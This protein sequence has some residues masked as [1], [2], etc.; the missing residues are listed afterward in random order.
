MNEVK[1]YKGSDNLPLLKEPRVIRPSKIFFW[2]KCSKQFLNFTIFMILSSL[3]IFYFSSSTATEI[4]RIELLKEY[5]KILIFLFWIPWFIFLIVYII[6]FYY[7]GKSMVF[8]VFENGIKVKKGL[9]YISE[10]YIPF[11]T[12]TYVE[13]QAGP[14]DTFFD[15][16]TVEI[17]TT[18]V[19]YTPGERVVEKLEGIKNYCEVRDSLL[20][21]LP[22][23]QATDWT[24]VSV[25]TPT[26]INR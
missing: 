18:G 8:S 26:D 4:Q 9:F 19:Q 14:L 22:H 23:S 17:W 2:K 7:Y 10:R 24:S 1:K 13:I 25:A 6:G 20:V 16:G 5:F 15:I 11:E 3:L 12:I 21:Q